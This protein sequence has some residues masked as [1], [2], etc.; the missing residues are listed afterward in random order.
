[1]SNSKLIYFGRTVYTNGDKILMNKQRHDFMIQL[2]ERFDSAEYICYAKDLDNVED[3]S[4][5]TEID[6]STLTIKPDMKWKQG[7]MSGLISRPFR[8]LPVQRDDQYLI[9]YTFFPGSFSFLITPQIFSICDLNILYF[10]QDARVTT[11]GLDNGW[12]INRLQRLGFSVGQRY[13]LRNADHTFVRDPR[14]M[15]ISDDFGISVSKPVSPYLGEIQ[16]IT[17]PVCR[18]E[19]IQI[20]YVGNFRKPKGHRY[21][22]EAA[23]IMRQSADFNFEI[24]LIGDGPTRSAV[25]QQVE[26]SEL[27]NIVH[28]V[29]HL[30]DTEALVSE[31]RSA[32]VF[33]LPSETEGFPR[34]LNEAMEAK[35]PI[36]STSV[37][38]IPALL[39]NRENALLVPSGNPKALAEGINKVVSNEKLRDQIISNNEKLA[40]ELRGDPV[41]QHIK[42][43]QELIRET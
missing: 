41:E 23:A 20:L 7:G 3:L 18:E 13:V 12:I 31:Y 28:F 2:A 1:M 9:S 17:R 6:S 42:K 29:G 22:V 40:A 32:D 19:P 43:I 5:V 26:E 34:V 30:E 24:R 4:L 11:Q 8:R 16:N 14:V 21:L 25:E 36:V 10:G 15:N 35:L 37:G 27:S 39:S 38:G 33:A